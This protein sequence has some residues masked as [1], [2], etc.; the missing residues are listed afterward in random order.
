MA[1]ATGCAA[2][3]SGASPAGEDSLRKL[4]YDSVLELV[5]GMAS[6][7]MGKQL[8]LALRPA[9]GREALEKLKR[10]TLEAVDLLR[11]GF[12]FPA[13]AVDVLEGVILALDSGVVC[14]EPSLLRLA[15]EALHEFC[16]ACSEAKQ[17][18][19]EGS[20]PVLAPLLEDLPD[21][22]AVAAE[23]IR[24]TTPDGGIAPNASS[25]LAKLTRTAERLRDSLSK[26]IGRMA[27]S[28]SADGIL[29]DIPPSIRNGRFVLPV[30][31]GRRSRVPGI[32]H[33]RS[34]TGGTVFIEPQSLT[35]AGNRLQEVLVEVQQEQRRILR[36]ATALVRANS[37]CMTKG[38]D[39]GSEL[40]SVLA[41]ARF[42]I[43][44]RTVFPEDGPLS[45]L[46]LRHPLLPAGEMVANDLVLP[47][48][49][50]VLVVSGPNAG[51]KSVLIKSAGLA[52]ACSLSGLGACVAPG[53]TM[54]SL[55]SIRVSMG[56][57]Q[58]L[59]Q[60]LST[61][62]ARLAEELE[63]LETADAGMLVLLD[64]PSAGTDPLPGAAMAAAFLEALTS[65]G[66]RCIVTTHLGQLKT[67]A[68]D[69]PG[70]Y[71]GSMNFDNSTLAPDYTFRFGIPGSSFTLEIAGR[72]G[73]PSSILSTAERLAGDAFVLDRLIAELA[74]SVA[75]ARAE[76]ASLER[77]RAAAERR[78]AEFESLIGLQRADA[79]ASAEQV[80]KDAMEMIRE[81][82]SRSDQL[83]A[84]IAA[85]DS[86][87]RKRARGEIRKLSTEA[88]SVLSRS[89]RSAVPEK[90]AKLCEGGWVE[91]SGW[92]GSAGMIESIRGKTAQVRLGD[93]LVDK[94]LADLKPVDR[95]AEKKSV[96][97]WVIH[98]AS[99]EIDLRGL[100]SEDALLE[101][102]G[103]MDGCV[104]SGV[105]RLR[106]IHGKGTGALM[107]AVTEYLRRDR[108]V[109]SSAM[110]E[111]HE[112]GTGV[113]IAILR[114]QGGG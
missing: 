58:S 104:A 110:A 19:R 79:E 109:V 76:T 34:D 111:P 48:D 5:C 13:G 85:G 56:D 37:D 27:E 15:G 78:E 43:Q 6:S 75:A 80:R 60:K 69:H 42:S 32:V 33:D 92:P 9:S 28:L 29:R 101:L 103:R 67:L 94:Q 62:S 30:L 16:G 72:M 66:A 87:E 7:A 57:S 55:R 52:V 8:T 59:V 65:A 45:L 40:D 61:Y 100:T 22:P 38:R 95:P 4:E 39:A 44:W 36:D 70:Y 3:A 25:Q 21:I 35:E 20:F 89:S 102:D 90:D 74:S 88:E 99:P 97:G 86:E 18:L 2:G 41:R 77:A 113:T 71:N 54:P 47:D 11:M 108:R 96:A 82:G 17:L 68:S 84:R 26:E 107:K 51:G 14:L 114:L 98:P 63:M 24:I 31:S 23:L 53:S 93:V 81:L 49:W 1:D 91:V 106:I 83:L 112:G 64:E 10:Q 46:G 50:K 105:S 73:F 12:V